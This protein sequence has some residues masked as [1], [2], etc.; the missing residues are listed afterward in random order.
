[1]SS[2]FEGVGANAV[3]RTDAELDRTML[4]RTI[5]LAELGRTGARPNPVVGAVLARADGT[6]LATGHHPRRGEPH[7]ERFCL[8]DA[9]ADIPEDATLYVSLEPCNHT[10][11]QP[12]CSEH[13]L[14][15]GVRRV[16]FA[17]CD[18]NPATAG[19]GP[20]R[21]L[22]GGVEVVRGP[23]D[24][25][26]AALQQNAGF[27]SVHL[28]GRPYVTAKFAMTRNGRFATGD[29]SRRWITGEESRDFVHYMRAGSGAIV[30]GIGTVLADDPLLTVRGP[31]AAR[32][33]VPPIRVVFDRQLQLPLTSQLVR[34]IDDAPVLVVCGHDASADRELGLSA[35]GVEVWRAPE[36]APGTPCLP[37]AALNMLAEHRINDVLLEAGPRLLDAFQRAELVDSVTAFVAPFDAPDEQPG[38]PLDHPLVIAA[39]ANGGET[40]GEDARYVGLIHPAWQFPGAQPG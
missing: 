27:H 26:R 7:A 35:V 1:V 29:D 32:T 6:V 39:L 13:V 17:C 10:G 36:P 20:E 24:L 34:T 31:L 37:A 16:V 19:M 25:E 18:P 14:E 28:R 40:S 33:S 3:P 12:P 15:R 9:P 38:L 8:A 23:Q 21:L 5:E 2:T 11:L 30:V 22:R 4:A